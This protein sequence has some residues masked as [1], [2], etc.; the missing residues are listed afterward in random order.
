MR[1][2]GAERRP[3]IGLGQTVEPHHRG[4]GRPCPRTAERDETKAIGRAL[5]P[6]DS[7]WSRSSSAGALR[8]VGD[9]RRPGPPRRP[10]PDR[11]RPGRW[12]SSLRRCAVDPCHQPVGLGERG[13]TRPVPEVDGRTRERHSGRWSRRRRP[14][15][16]TAPSGPRAPAAGASPRCPASGLG[17]VVGRG[18]RRAGVATGPVPRQ[19]QGQASSRPPR[20]Q[21]RQLS[22]THRGWLRQAVRVD[23]IRPP[24][25]PP[26]ATARAWASCRSAPRLRISS[27]GRP[28]STSITG[29]MFSAMSR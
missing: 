17:E 1:Q 16:P 15:R 4:A 25:S 24:Q 3:A 29:K 19:A 21:R 28:A 14:A 20:G 2:Q 8:A 11:A 13:Q 7:A 18:A 9:R 26:P 23:R 5:R 10:P 12:A 22:G 6:A 27:M